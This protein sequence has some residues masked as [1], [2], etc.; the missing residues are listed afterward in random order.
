[1]ATVT[2]AQKLTV[3][4]TRAE[5]LWRASGNLMEWGRKRV[6]PRLEESEVT[7]RLTPIQKDALLA[8]MN[9]QLTEIRAA[10]KAMPS[11]W[12]NFELTA[13]ELAALVQQEIPPA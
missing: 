10:A 5:R 7:Q 6:R 8:E 13:E 11:D 3:L 2:A 1:M 9:A 12:V 4:F